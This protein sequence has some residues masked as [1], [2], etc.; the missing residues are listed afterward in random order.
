VI[1]LT[2][3][4]P[5]DDMPAIALAFSNPC[6]DVPVYWGAQRYNN[7]L[8]FANPLVRFIDEIPNSL[9]NIFHFNLL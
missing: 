5:C 2:F 7:F 9:D 3:S 1:A 6:D 4:N 8:R